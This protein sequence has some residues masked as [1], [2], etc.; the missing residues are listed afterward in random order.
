MKH[1]TPVTNLPILPLYDEFNNLLA[2]KKLSWNSQRQICINSIP[3]HEND[4]SFGAGGLLYDWNAYDE[5]KHLIN[6][7][8]HVPLREMPLE[9]KDFTELCTAFK[10]TL[11]EELYIELKSKYTLGRIRIME[12][13]PKSC[14]TWHIDTS[15]R[16]HYP[17]KTQ[18]GCLMIIED[19]VFHIP[20][21][22]WWHTNTTV[23]HTAL[24]GSKEL[25]YHLV[26]AILD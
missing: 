20:Q 12:S 11:F 26:V 2:Q 24:N 3:G 4:T 22:E 9:E 15:S 1:F 6:G 19:E 21:N 7:V 13:E 14:L 5:E 25:R 8:M 17:L 18:E 23:Y 16:L 10:G